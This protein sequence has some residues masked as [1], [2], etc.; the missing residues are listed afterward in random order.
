MNL[1][2]RLAAGQ[3]R[4]TA[5]DASAIRSPESAIDGFLFG[6]VSDATRTTIAKATDA[7]KMLALTLGAPEFQRR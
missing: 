3:L 2:L 4:G 6:D 5:V 1:A 7:T